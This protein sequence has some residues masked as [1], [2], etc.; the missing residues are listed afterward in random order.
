MVFVQEAQRQ[1]GVGNAVISEVSQRSIL[2]LKAPISFVSAP[3]TVFPFAQ[4]ENQWLPSAADII[5]AINETT[6]F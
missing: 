6:D 4:M 2:S 3:D 5:E 1:A